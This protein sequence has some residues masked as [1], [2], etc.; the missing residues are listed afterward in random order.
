MTPGHQQALPEPHIL[1]YDWRYTSETVTI[2]SELVRNSDSVLA[3][4]TPSLA[5]YLES[6]GHEVLLVDRQ[7]IHAVRN[8]RQMEPG[9][10]PPDFKKRTIAVIDPPWYLTDA[11]V[12]I[13]WTAHGIEPRSQMLVSLWPDT[14][15]PTA[16]K[17]FEELKSWIS[18]WAEFEIL[19]VVPR[20]NTPLFEAVALKAS[21]SPS[22]GRSPRYG[23]LVSI[24]PRTL[25]DLLGPPESRST[26]IRFVVDDYQLAICLKE[27]QSLTCPVI[28]HPI[29]KHWIWPYVSKRAR[30]RDLINLWSSRNEVAL[31][32]DPKL[33]VETLRRALKAADPGAFRDQLGPYSR[34][35]DL[36]IPRPP[37]RRL[38]EWQHQQ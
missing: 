9:Y 27:N 13:A 10:G 33:A 12:W 6:I 14:T 37:Y 21:E 1:D 5:R 25:P 32:R 28:Q 23:R 8:H 29:A 17:E 22:M 19:D 15:R 24:R 36:S 18:Q 7:P 31:L 11:R 2:L 3:V 38:L 35:H 20:Y 4:G 30:E 16:A 34:L 26:W